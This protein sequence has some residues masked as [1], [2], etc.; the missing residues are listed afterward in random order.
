M[1]PAEG[2]I[3][4]KI[5]GVPY[6]LP[7]GQNIADHKPELKLNTTA[8]LIWEAICKGMD[9]QEILEILC[10]KFNADENTRKNIKADLDGYIH[11]LQSYGALEKEKTFKY[12]PD[13]V[14]EYYKT[15]KI[16]FAFYGPGTIYRKYFQAFSCNKDEKAECCQEIRFYTGEP[17][18]HA[19][20]NILVR[21]KDISIIDGSSIYIFI[22]PSGYGAY[23]MHV[24]KDGSHADIFCP[25]FPGKQQEEDI[26][27]ALRFAFLIIAGQNG[28][29][30]IH[31]ASL[32]YRGFAWLFSGCSGT[33]KSTHTNL[34]HSLFGTEILNGDLN[35]ISLGNGRPVTYGLPWCGTSGIF[36]TKS[37]PLGGIIFLKQAS[38]NTVTIPSEDEKTILLTQRLLS[39]SWNAELIQDNLHFSEEMVKKTAIFRLDCTKEPEAAYVIKNK[40]DH[41]LDN[42]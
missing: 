8:M 29:H 16:K 12:I 18:Y 25:P 40:I 24:S 34:W 36:T 3:L 19:N 4:Q 7:Y 27:H 32:L 6:L 39:P 41:M 26:F 10:N 35:I 23:E 14:P 9:M 33:G 20:G 38:G 42:L 2:Y 1:K 21:N 13:T 15:G 37:Y 5:C 30:I 22:F 31:S 11:M 17:R 28:L